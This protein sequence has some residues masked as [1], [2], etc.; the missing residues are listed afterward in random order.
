MTTT[1][2]A[3]DAAPAAGKGSKPSAVTQA[4][5]DEQIQGAVAETAWVG[6]S[7]VV[8]DRTRIEG[9]RDQGI[10]AIRRR[11]MS[12]ST[13][14]NVTG[15]AAR[16]AIESMLPSVA[17]PLGPAELGSGSHLILERFYEREPEKRTMTALRRLVK[18]VTREQLAAFEG[19]PQYD[20]YFAEVS[21]TIGQW[22][23]KIFD[24]EKPSEVNVYKTEMEFKGIL[25]SNGVPFVGYLDRTDIDG[26]PD[27]LENA[28]LLIKDYK[29]GGKVKRPSPM[30]GDHYGDQMRLYDDAVEQVFGKPAGSATLIWPRQK[31]LVPADLSPAAKRATL[32]AFKRSYDYMNSTADAAVFP[33]TPSNLCGWCPAVNSCP[34]ASVK[35]EKAKANARKMHGGPE[36]PVALGIP[37]VREFAAAPRM[38]T[39]DGS[40]SPATTT[41]ETIVTQTEQN[42]LT[43]PTN[44]WSVMA[45]AALTDSAATHLDIYG[46]PLKPAT[47]NALATVLGGIA[48]AVHRQVFAGGFD[49][50]FDSA[51]RVAYS[52]NASLRSRPAPFGQ[53]AQAW[54]KWRQTLIG[55]TA[56]KLRIAIPLVEVT[57][58]GA[59]NFDAL[60]VNTTIP[61]PK[62]TSAASAAVE[63]EPAL[64]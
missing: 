24:L 40:P 9:D 51:S 57:D 22:A 18:P 42:L 32:A 4:V 45:T 23:E 10:R 61:E 20:D 62:S 52:L 64:A 21:K 7:L 5:S 19:T 29:F 37:T 8:G 63:A 47:I 53:D 6:K 38:N 3:T 50:S 59:P 36:G 30:F 44:K 25:L 31:Q 54:D 41:Q 46:Q 35:S 43:M 27:D 55:L 1:L 48:E 12:A 58:F 15:C 14:Q 11:N 33:A 49:W 34:V 13:A 17:N 39:V 60:L 16:F 2:P 26:D 28:T 56:A